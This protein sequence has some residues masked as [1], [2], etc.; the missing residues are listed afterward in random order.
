[1]SSSPSLEILP[2]LAGVAERN[3]TAG[4]EARRLRHAARAAVA[5]CKS[6]RT[7]M[8]WQRRGDKAARVG[9]WK[10]VQSEKGG[11]LFDLAADPG[12]TKD[13]SAAKPEV[14]ARL[15]SRFAAW[16]EEMDA[17]EPR[18]PFRDY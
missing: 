7:E 11:G 5:R 18:G 2:T 8:F 13:L 3:G 4:G 17:A 16:R 1:M 12:E 10:W 14:L 6:P 9:Q 15:K